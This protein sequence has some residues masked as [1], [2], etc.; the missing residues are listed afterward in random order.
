MEISY[1][2]VYSGRNI[3]SH[4]PVIKIL[5]DLGEYA[6]KSTDQLPLFTD[7]L[8][9]L[10]PSLREHHCSR[11]YRGGF[12]QRLHEGT[13][14]GHVVEHI[15]LELQN[16]AGLQAVYGKTRSTDDPNVYEIVVEYQSAAAAKEAAYQSV[17]IV[18]ALLK[19]KA[20]PELEVIIKRL[21][22]I[23][24]RFELGPT[25]RT[26]VQAALARDLPVL[27]L[28]DNSLIQ[29]G[30]GV[31]Q[32]RV[33]AA[34]TSLTSCLAVDI[35][36]DKSRTKKMLRRVAILVPEGRLVLSEEEALAAFY[37]LK[38]PV[39][40]KPESGNQGKGV[41]LNLKNVAEVRAAYTLARNFGRRV[42]VEKH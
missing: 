7:R 37:E 27:R 24:A 40:L 22:D 33:E 42:L 23:A 21:Q 17:S 31:A 9:S 14:L 25:S 41:S 13:Y 6:H 36:G 5:L 18:N 39:V 4:Y 20:P 15:I 35:A 19:G 26:L 8:L 3:Y 38:G 32:R 16:L 10:I 30:Y 1:I 11:G 34:L 28:D 2:S 12:V 29:I